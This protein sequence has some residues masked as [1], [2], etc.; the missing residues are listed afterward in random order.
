MFII[1]FG[2][3]NKKCFYFGKMATTGAV[4]ET[5]MGS[6]VGDKESLGSWVRQKAH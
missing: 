3:Q 5:V 2:P 1:P 4:Q 6:L